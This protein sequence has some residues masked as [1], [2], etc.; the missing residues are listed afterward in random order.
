MWYLCETTIKSVHKFGLRGSVYDL[1]GIKGA[2][3]YNEEKTSIKYESPEL[4][5]VRVLFSQKCQCG[6]FQSSLEGVV[7]RSFD[8]NAVVEHTRVYSPVSEPTNPVAVLSSDYITTDNPNSGEFSVF[9]RLSSS[10][11]LI[12]GPTMQPILW[13]NANLSCFGGGCKGK[14]CHLMSQTSYI[15]HA[16][17]ANNMLIMSA[18]NHDRFDG[19]SPKIAICWVGVTDRAVTVNE[20]EVTFCDIAIECLNADVYKCVGTSIKTGTKSDP[21]NMIYFTSV[22]VPNPTQFK[23]FLTFKYLENKGL[24]QNI[25]VSEKELAKMSR[26][27]AEVKVTMEQDPDV[28]IDLNIQRKNKRI[29]ATLE[30]DNE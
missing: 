10:D 23:Q 4:L 25:N 30:V 22:A 9:S 3:H 26:V 29:L 16:D 2:F 8:N 13:E 17:N 21:D 20:E 6:S 12:V 27:R 24:Q 19:Y 7:K 15:Q 5:A 18:E 14:K 11:D 1:A 28:T